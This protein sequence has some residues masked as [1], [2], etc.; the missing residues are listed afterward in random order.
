MDAYVLHVIHVGMVGS[1]AS[2]ARNAFFH[3]NTVY[4]VMYADFLYMMEFAIAVLNVSQ[5]PAIVV[6]DV[7]RL[8][9]NVA[10]FIYQVNVH[11]LFAKHACSQNA[12]A[13]NA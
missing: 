1:L 5:H 10:T 9:A 2:V 4:V 6:G 12:T 7:E 11:A 8:F 3:G 13:G